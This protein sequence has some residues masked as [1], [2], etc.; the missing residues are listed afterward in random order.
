[1]SRYYKTRGHEDAE[2]RAIHNRLSSSGIAIRL[3][4]LRAAG[5]STLVDD[6]I[7]FECISSWWVWEESSSRLTDDTRHYFCT[8]VGDC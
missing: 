5:D 3:A 1:M 7:H 6:D 8:Y 4:D 2:L